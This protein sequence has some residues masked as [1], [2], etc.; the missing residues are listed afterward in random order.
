MTVANRPILVVGDNVAHRW[1]LAW[2]LHEAGI[3]AE[4]A[5]TMEQARQRVGH[6]RLAGVVV[7]SGSAEL[8]VRQLARVVQPDPD[9]GEIP[10][11]LDASQA[12]T[13]AKVVAR[14]QSLLQASVSS[15]PK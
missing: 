6:G 3:P 8:T 14:V 1:D 13:P 4:Q 7:D 15:E 2:A 11:I 9:T 10:F 5:A 12:S